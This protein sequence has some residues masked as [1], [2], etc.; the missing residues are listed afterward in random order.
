MSSPHEHPSGGRRGRQVRSRRPGQPSAP[1]RRGQRRATSICR[2]ER[3]L[4]NPDHEAF[5]AWF[6]A[7]WRRHGAQLFADQTTN[8]GE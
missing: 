2:H 4:A 3:R 1:T 5:V 8:G 6:V 7:Y